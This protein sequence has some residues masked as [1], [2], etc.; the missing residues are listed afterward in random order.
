MC[1]TS[2][3]LSLIAI[4]PSIEGLYRGVSN[5]PEYKQLKNQTSIR[6]FSTIDEKNFFHLIRSIM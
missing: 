6:P 5:R 2:L 4:R 1:E 3:S